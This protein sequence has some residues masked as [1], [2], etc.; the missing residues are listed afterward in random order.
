MKMLVVDDDPDFCAALELCLRLSW[1]TWTILTAQ[2]AREALHL[3][4][5]DHPDLV[6]MDLN[7]PDTD[8]FHLCRAMRESLAAPIMVLTCRTAE[9]DKVRALEAGADD[10]VTKPYGAMELQARLRALLRR[11]ASQQPSSQLSQYCYEQ[12][13]IDF[14]SRRVAVRGRRLKLTPIEYGILYHLIQGAPRVLTHEELLMKI[15]GQQ[16]R[17]E[18]EYVRVHIR[19]LR[20][21][22]H[23]DPSQPRFI[24]TEHSI[25]YRFLGPRPV[26]GLAEPASHQWE[27]VG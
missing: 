25:G 12:L 15:W 19:H 17:S 9:M 5:R 13:S 4:R 24:A 7:L 22:L 21:K 8:G 6:I 16:Y 11:V 23:D 2:D 3:V 26:L 27:A 20:Q 18:K 10:Y 1:D 14:A